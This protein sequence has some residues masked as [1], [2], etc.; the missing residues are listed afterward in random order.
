MKNI[1]FSGYFGSGKTTAANFL[2][3]S[4]GYSK[5]S[6]GK[7]V[8]EIADIMFGT[9][10]KDRKVYQT[11]GGLGRTVDQDVWIKHLDLE[12]KQNFQNKLIVV[13]DLRHK[14]EFLYLKNQ[15]FVTVRIHVDDSILHSRPNFDPV[16]AQHESEVDLLDW[17]DK[18]DYTV[19]NSKGRNNFYDQ[20]RSILEQ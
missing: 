11:I 19:D 1:A 14:N 15:D 16:F 2:V 13:E 18:F 7:K 3:D 5:V 4:F 17:L 9:K 6:F 10:T 8:K 12:L 20:I